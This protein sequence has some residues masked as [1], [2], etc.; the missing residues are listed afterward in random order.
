M[1]LFALLLAVQSLIAPSEV[2]ARRDRLAKEIGPNAMLI[3]FSARPKARDMDIDYPYRQSDAM[4]YLTGVDQ[5]DATL[6]ML[7]GE[8]GHRD[9]L[10]V[11]DS[12]PRQEMWTGHIYTHKEVGD[13][14]GINDIESNNRLRAFINTALGGGPWD[15]ANV[16]A[17]RAMPSFY[18]AVR[19]GQAELWLPLGSE[20]LQQSFVDEF[21][22]AHPDIRIRNVTPLLIAMREVKSPAEIAVMQK[23]ID[24]S[25]A[26]QKAGMR[27]AKT[28][29]NEREVQAVI[30]STFREQG[31]D[32]LAYPS[33]VASGA[34]ATTL[35]YEEDDEPIDRNGL[36]LTDVGAEVQG[37]AA[38]TTR[39]YPVSGRF[40]PEQR[41]IYDAVY[42]A[43][44]AT[45]NAMKPGALWV[46]VDHVT[47][48]TIGRE[49]MKLGLVSKNDPTQ[50]RMYLPY[51]VGHHIG[52]A[53]HDVWDRG[54]PLEP[55]M[56]VTDEPGIYV[57]R[58]DVLKN[59]TYLGLTKE[60]QASIAKALD[61]YNGIGVR[62]ED[63]VLVTNDGSRLLTAAAPRSAEE[64]ERF[65]Q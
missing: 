58:D 38:D 23:A 49:L 14:S 62:L 29:T 27:R 30:E 36:M 18:N 46:E 11:R 13:T 65:L 56:I 9:T 19:S 33:I 45:R 31:A 22:S 51:L 28:A 24:I 40:T 20:D 61:K 44:E 48:D 35:H 1:N 34:N 47:T 3:V 39:T 53:V 21:R 60:E 16:D 4:L 57:R 6:V 12:N 10:F 7:P 26:G 37:Y 43:N 32:A 55:G 63:E 17:H 5:P 41:A 25:L 54:R 52:L 59:P 50:V 42:A 2:Q 15:S 8:T 64:I